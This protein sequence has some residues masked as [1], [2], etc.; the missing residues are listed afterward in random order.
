MIIIKLKNIYI[1]FGWLND[2]LLVMVQNIMINAGVNT[3]KWATSVPGAATNWTSI[4]DTRRRKN[5]N[6]MKTG[7]KNSKEVSR[8]IRYNNQTTQYIC[9]TPLDS[10]NPVGFDKE[11]MFPACELFDGSWDAQTIDDKGYVLAF[12]SDYANRIGGTD[13][14][15]FGRPVTAEKMEVYINDIYRTAYLLHTKTVED[16]HKVKL[17]RYQLNPKDLENA[18]VNPIQA[19]YYQFGPKGLE[20]VSKVAG[21]PSF[22]SQPHFLECDNRLIADVA[23]MNPNPDIHK[24]YLDIEPQTGLLVRARKRLQV[25]YYIS[26][27]QF[28]VLDP[29][30]AREFNLLCVN[31]NVSET[32]NCSGFDQTVTCLTTPTWNI[33]NNGVLFPYA[34]VEEGMTLTA[35]DADSLK[36]SLYWIEEFATQIQFWCYVS[37]GLL[38]ILLFGMLYESMLRDEEMEY[39]YNNIADDTIAIYTKEK[40]NNFENNNN[41]QNNPIN[42]NMIISNNDINRVLLG[43]NTIE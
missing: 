32:I 13:A 5:L 35:D 40:E 9:F 24:T 15:M 22:V 25:N 30:R 4:E 27:E 19:Q 41:N 14:Q 42:N 33:Y 3:D 1:D 29:V 34:W 11:T 23:G 39:Q 43:N 28:P 12:N 36:N 7:K 10:N 17:R 21:F 2:P 31:T 20:N 8:F 38:S 26:S 37:A 18:T 6:T 16:W